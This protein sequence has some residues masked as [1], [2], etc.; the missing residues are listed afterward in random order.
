MGRSTPSWIK[1]GT[2]PSHATVLHATVLPATVLH[3]IAAPGRRKYVQA[4]DFA[5]KAHSSALRAKDAPI[6]LRLI[7]SFER[8]VRASLALGFVLSRSK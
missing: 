5:V 4:G 6:C 1:R 8:G 7:G 2:Y 3:A